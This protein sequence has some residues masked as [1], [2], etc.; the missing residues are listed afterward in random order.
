MKK[1]EVTVDTDGNVEVATFGF[2]GAECQKATADLERQ[3][4]KV[5]D[6]AVTPEYHKRP[7]ITIKARS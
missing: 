1:I 3:L 7:A 2:S 5:M 4:G 6:D